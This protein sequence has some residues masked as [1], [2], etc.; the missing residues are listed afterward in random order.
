MQKYLAWAD[1]YQ[2]NQITIVYDTMWMPP[3]GWLKLSLRAS[4]NRWVGN[5]QVDECRQRGQERHH[6]RSFPLKAILVGSPTIN[7][8][9]LSS[10]GAFFEIIR[11]LRFSGK[12]AAA[13]GSYGWSGESVKLMAED[14]AE[15]GF[16]LVDEGCRVMWKPDGDA[17]DACRD[18]GRRFGQAL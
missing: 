17:L 14:T 10:I 9:Y 2:E 4:K 12:K 18:F 16:E 3:G 11:G 5:D 8:R 6:Y 13:F 1:S 15:A 7:R